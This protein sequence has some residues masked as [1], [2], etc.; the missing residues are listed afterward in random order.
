VHGTD[1]L[2]AAEQAAQAL[3]G[4]A[5][6]ADLTEPALAAALAEA[7]HARLEAGAD[8]PSVVDALVATGLADSRSAARRTVSEG[9]AYVNNVRVSE[10]DS[11]L[12]E[13][14][15]LHGRWLVI[16]KGKRSVAG[17]EVVRT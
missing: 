11:P 14:A 7:P 5:E 16:R 9:G 3:F 2:R 10:A 17:A 15:L 13:A 6:L 12:P 1:E 4:R 8:L